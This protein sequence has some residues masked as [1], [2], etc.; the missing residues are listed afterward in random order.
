VRRDGDRADRES[1][2]RRLV[3][4]LDEALRR[5]QSE[6]KFVLLDFFAPG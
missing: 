3:H 6:Q 5:A 4:D 1:P 2:A